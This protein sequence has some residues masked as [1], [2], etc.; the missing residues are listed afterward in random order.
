M[1]GLMLVVR[2]MFHFDGSRTWFIPRREYKI[3]FAEVT[4]ECVI[5]SFSPKGHMEDI[6]YLAK[7][8]AIRM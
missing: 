3:D 5:T 8:V 1:N 6:L 2:K 4:R 7:Y